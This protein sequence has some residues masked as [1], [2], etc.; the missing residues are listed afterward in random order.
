[1]KN[2]LYL[3][4]DKL[5][6]DLAEIDRYLEHYKGEPLVESLRRIREAQKEEEKA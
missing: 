3:A 6:R 2:A 1:M 4:I 5:R